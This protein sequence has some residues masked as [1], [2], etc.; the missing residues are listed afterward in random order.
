MQF[1]LQL[2][3]LKKGDLSIRD[4][5]GKIK[6]FY[7]LLSSAGHRVTDEDQ[8]L[9]ILSG[10]GSDYDAVMVT[11]TSRSE[12]WRL[13]DVHALLMTFEARLESTHLISTSNTEG[14]Q[15]SVN[16]TS[17]SFPKNENLRG[18]SHG[19]FHNNN[20][21][22]IGDRGSNR[23]Q[24]PALHMAHFPSTY[25]LSEMSYENTWYPDSGATNHVSNDLATL[26]TTAKYHGGNRLQMGNG[27]G[28]DIAHIGQQG[29]P[30]QGYS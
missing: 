14:S 20:Q 27:M 25:A 22:Y 26:N 4:Y 5:I 10:L 9:H 21:S 3:N 30:P 13:Q 7:D 29:N 2:Q 23:G 15:P 19:S 1:K 8:I 16:Y 17:Q 11:I 24:N 18:Q 28:V 6:N 12:S